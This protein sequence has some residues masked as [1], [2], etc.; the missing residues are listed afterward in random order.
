MLKLLKF[1]RR[2]AAAHAAFLPPIYPALAR[3]GV[4]ERGGS[5]TSANN[6]VKPTVG[7]LLGRSI[8]LYSLW[9]RHNA[10]V[11]RTEVVPRGSLSPPKRTRRGG[12]RASVTV[13]CR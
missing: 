2:A 3:H 7:S 1:K 12:V 4:G 8:D 11:G 9:N 5:F 6:S 13:L 10:V